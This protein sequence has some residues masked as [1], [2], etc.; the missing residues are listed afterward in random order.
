MKDGII[1]PKVLVA[2]ELS[3][4]WKEI[5]EMLEDDPKEFWILYYY[6]RGMKIKEAEDVANMEHKIKQTREK[7]SPKA[8]FPKDFVS[9]V[10]KRMV[11]LS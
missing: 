5:N 10:S 11:D 3:I 8:S 4:S 2:M 6:I 1:P 7:S 9:Q